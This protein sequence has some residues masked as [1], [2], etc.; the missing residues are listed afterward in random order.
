[1]WAKY[2]SL[3][4]NS[5]VFLLIITDSPTPINCMATLN[6]VRSQNISWD[7]SF[8]EGAIILLVNNL[9]I[10]SST[11]QPV[12]LVGETCY[13]FRADNLRSCD[14]YRFR[15]MGRNDARNGSFV[16]IIMSLFS[17]PDMSAVEDSLKQSLIKTAGRV[18]LRVTFQV[19]A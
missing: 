7:S 13:I 16:N 10:T 14:A 6:G 4:E 12:A 11:T 19:R 9:N 1:M 17:L 18:T 3:Q 15:V 2:S 5:K 8:I